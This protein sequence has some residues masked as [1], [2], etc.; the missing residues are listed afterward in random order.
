M[1]VINMSLELLFE[2]RKVFKRYMNIVYMKHV[3]IN[4]KMMSLGDEIDGKY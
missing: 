3:N 1:E 2:I 4:H